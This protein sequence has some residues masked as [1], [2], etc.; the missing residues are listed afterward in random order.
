MHDFICFIDN[1]SNLSHYDVW[2]YYDV[3]SIYEEAIRYDFLSVVHYGIK[4][5][6]SAGIYS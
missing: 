4:L 2:F 5:L 6:V 1:L 3:S